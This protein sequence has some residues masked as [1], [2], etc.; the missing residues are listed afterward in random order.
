MGSGGPKSIFGRPRFIIEELFDRGGLGKLK[1]CPG[2]EY[3]SLGICNA[4]VGFSGRSFDEC[5]L[6]L[7]VCGGMRAAGDGSADTAKPI[8]LALTDGPGSRSS[9]SR[10]VGWFGGGETFLG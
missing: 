5:L 7:K 1:T 8:L 10:I 6:S 9:T 2:R 4:K 3:V